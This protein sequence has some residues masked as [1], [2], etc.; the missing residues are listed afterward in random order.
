M[1]GFRNDAGAF[2]QYLLMHYFVSLCFNSI[3]HL[4]SSALPNVIIATQLQGLLF[5]FGFLFGGIFIHPN[6][7]PAGWKWVYYINPLPKGVNGIAI[8]Q[9][10]D[11]DIIDVNG[12]PTGALTYIV[13]TLE[14]GRDTFWHLF[15]W[16][17]LILVVFRILIIL[18]LRFINHS[19]R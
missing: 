14:S 9:F 13:N 15:G 16:L 17:V 10:N 18:A 12:V 19:K 3:G 2:F 11:N 5:F 1:V 4:M 6:T 7:I 8:T